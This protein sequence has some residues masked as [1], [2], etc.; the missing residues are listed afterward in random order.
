MIN[1]EIVY[2]LIKTATQTA[3]IIS[4]EAEQCSQHYWLQNCYKITTISEK[5]YYS[6][7]P[8]KLGCTGHTLKIVRSK[9]FNKLK[10]K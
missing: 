5:N 8:K 10:K 2:K 4:M 9:G 1:K 7:C 6:T 3:H